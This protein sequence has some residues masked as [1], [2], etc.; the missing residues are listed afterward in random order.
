MTRS[1]T[2]NSTLTAAAAAVLLWSGSA[3]AQSGNP[4]NPY[5]R[6]Q[7]Q[8]APPTAPPTAPAP[9]P[10]PKYYQDPI[11]QQPDRQSPPPKPSRFAPADLAQ[12]LSVLPRPATPPATPYGYPSFNSS[13]YTNAPAYSGQRPA[14]SGQLQGYYQAPPQGNR[15]PN[16]SR[17]WPQNYGG[18]GPPIIGNN[19]WGTAP[20][21]NFFPFGF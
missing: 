20:R 15:A 9:A 13:P 18:Y 14:Y 6:Q 12:R 3:L 1:Q 2:Y 10:K 5:P 8:S 4:W 7:V 17:N 21:N 11:P 16:Q 19:N